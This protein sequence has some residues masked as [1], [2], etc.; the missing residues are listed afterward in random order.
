MTLLFMNPSPIPE[1]KRTD[2]GLLDAVNLKLT[3]LIAESADHFPERVAPA[4]LGSAGGSPAGVGG[5]PTRT[6]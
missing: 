3:S 6:F 5:S 2:Q 4:I 1:L